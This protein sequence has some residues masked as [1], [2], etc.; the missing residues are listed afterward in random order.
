MLSSRSLARR[1]SEKVGDDIHG[2][3]EDDGRVALVCDVAQS[4]VQCIK[5]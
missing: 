1:S 3:W 5:V 4:L 2:H